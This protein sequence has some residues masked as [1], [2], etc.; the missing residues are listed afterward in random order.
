M[1]KTGCDWFTCHQCSLWVWSQSWKYTANT[2]LLVSTPQEVSHPPYYSAR[3][4]SLAALFTACICSEFGLRNWKLMMFTTH[5]CC[6]Q[7]AYV[8]MLFTGL[9]FGF[10]AELW[11]PSQSFL[12]SFWS[13][14]CV[15]LCW[16]TECM[17]TSVIQH[18]K[19]HIFHDCSW[20]IPHNHTRREARDVWCLPPVWS[21][22]AVI[23]F[24]FAI[25]S[26]V[27]LPSPVT[28]SIL[29]FSAC[30][31]FLLNFF[32]ENSSIFFH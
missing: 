12:T 21:L 28:L 13:Y 14:R 26:L 27:L 11:A 25:S 2:A 32:P 3:A 5:T 16:L 30:W 22:R 15:V 19:D 17:V 7:P 4:V 31:P 10:R 9:H 24:H 18:S 29:S 1:L 20:C 6:T 23:W 8:N